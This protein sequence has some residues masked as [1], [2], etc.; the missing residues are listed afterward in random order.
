MRR[1]SSRDSLGRGRR[2][3]LAAESARLHSKQPGRVVGQSR[4]RLYTPR[5]TAQAPP[6]TVDLAASRPAR[7]DPGR[8]GDV[9]QSAVRGGH[10]HDRGLRRRHEQR[11][12]R[13]PAD[14]M[15]VRQRL[16]S[17]TD[18]PPTHPSGIAAGPCPRSRSC[19]SAPRAAA[20]PR[21]QT[22]VDQVSALRRP[23]G[24]TRPGSAQDAMTA[25]TRSRCRG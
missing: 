18:I 20:K 10:H 12:D 22:T 7:I 1:P 6:P 9:Q 15:G 11:V 4:G 24:G 13:L 2:D 23:E 21:D 5:R 25:S 3:A 16:T 14:L 8:V 17:T 19:V